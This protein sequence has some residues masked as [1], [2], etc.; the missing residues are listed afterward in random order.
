MLSKLRRT[1][2]GVAPIVGKSVDGRRAEFHKYLHYREDRRRRRQF[3]FESK[4]RSVTLKRPRHDRAQDRR[5][6]NEPP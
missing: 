1:L 2:V 5:I 6:R 4:S 3:E